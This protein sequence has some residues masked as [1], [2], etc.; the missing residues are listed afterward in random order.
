MLIETITLCLF[1]F[2]GGLVDAAVGGG[3]LVVIPGL[4]T[5]L[6]T[7]DPATLLGTNKFSS[8]MGTSA[9]CWRYGLKI[10]LPW[11][12]LSYLI[13]CAFTG[14]FLGAA[15][16]DLLPQTW[17]RPMVLVLLVTM[18]I[19]TLV[20]KDFGQVH[21]PRVLTR[22]QLGIGLL[23]ASAIGFYDG[24]FG[25]GAGSL[26][27]F[28]FIRYFQFDFLA[29]S[30][31]SKVVNL[32][33]NIAA[34]CFFIPVDAVWYAF[35]IPMAVFSILGAIVGTKLAMHGGSALIR[36]LFIVLVSVIIVRLFIQMI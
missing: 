23:I 30:A 20:K 5:T 31:T 22:R 2:M 3:G 19:Y 8:A 27:I 33:T 25:P 18:L 13:A 1:A 7:A 15:T 21:A 10:K 14:A 6:P 35:A 11:R 12:L 4:F 17:V 29:A 36:K 32:S 9:A 26:L 28:L 16:A 34:L 24:F